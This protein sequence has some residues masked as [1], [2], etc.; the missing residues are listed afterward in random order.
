MQYELDK[1]GIKS[2]AGFA[3]QIKV[4][5][6]YAFSLKAGMTVEFETIDDVNLKMITP[7]QLDTQSH[8]FVCK[9]SNVAIQVKHTKVTNAVAQ[10]LLLNWILLE[11]SPYDVDKYILLTDKSYQNSGDIFV[12]DAKALHKIVVNSNK[13]VNAVITKVKNLYEK[14]YAEFEK[15][16]NSISTKFEFMDLDDIDSEIIEAASDHF[17]RVADEVVFYQRLGEFLQY[18][19]AQILNSV[20]NND[21][22]VL[23]YEEFISIIEDISNRFTPTDTAPSYSNFK[24]INKIDLKDS[25]VSQ[26]REYIQLKHCDLPDRLIEHNLLHGM[27]YHVTSLKY[28]ENNRMEK[29]NDIEDTAFENFENVKFDLQRNDRDAPYERL[30]MTQQQP[31]SYAD[32]DQIRLG[33]SIHLTKDSAGGRQI[34]WKDEDNE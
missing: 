13:G 23:K 6:Y 24:R 33:V 14:D 26:S 7:K 1:S 10:Q 8:N 20:S 32:N 34:S 16:Y 19:T 21:S 5:A 3:Y 12:K 29:I 22:F 15:M 25:K 11:S 27:Y 30:N 4:F 2:L 9:T 31:N 17:R 28:M 18:I